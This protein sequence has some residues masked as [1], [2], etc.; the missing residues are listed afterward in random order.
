MHLPA[1]AL[2]FAFLHT[3]KTKKMKKKFCFSVLMVV[4]FSSA[5]AQSIFDNPITGTNPNT[6][7]PYTIGQTVNANITASGIGRGSGIIGS[8]T[9]NRYNA[10]QWNT[11]MVIDVNDYFEFTLTPN[12]GTSIGFTSFVYTGQASATGPINF[13]FRSSLDGYAGN[14][15]TATAGG[16][17]I[18]LS[19]ITYQNISSAISFRFYGWAALASTGTFSINDFTFNGVAG[20]LPITIEYFKGTKQ[21]NGNKLSW[22]I[23]C[24]N[25]S[26]TVMHMERSKDGNNFNTI[27]TISADALTC[28]QPFDYT[29]KDF[30]QGYNYYRLKMTDADGKITFSNRIVLLNSNAAPDIVLLFPAIITGNTIVNITITQKIQAVIVITDYTGRSVQKRSCNLAAGSNAVQLQ[31][32]G[33]AAGVYQL[34]VYTT[35][36]RTDPIRFIKQ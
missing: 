21:V 13:A 12:P 17:T 25:S 10:S 9:N 20:V 1:L 29:D 27:K 7:N 36:Q 11:A 24:S 31:L 5:W 19:A 14:I 30:L 4:A 8:N 18:D 3:L 34:V 16:T 32:S 33:L 23:D 28:L 15:G 26:K 35:Q 2:A 22:K 6:S